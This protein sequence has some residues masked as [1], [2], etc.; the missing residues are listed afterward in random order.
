MRPIIL[1]GLTQGKHKFDL[2]YREVD[3]VEHCFVLCLCGFES[4]VLN[5]NNYGGVKHVQ[6]IWE[7]HVSVKPT[8][9]KKE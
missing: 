6:S 5:F 4:E 3:G 8:V 1:T 2:N 7:T 9:R